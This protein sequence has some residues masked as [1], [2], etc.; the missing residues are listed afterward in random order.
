MAEKFVKLFDLHIHKFVKHKFSI[1]CWFSS[2]LQGKLSGQVWSKCLCCLDPKCVTWYRTF[3]FV[4]AI[5]TLY[6]EQPNCI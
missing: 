5:Y 2:V 6:S 4:K 3:W 1:F